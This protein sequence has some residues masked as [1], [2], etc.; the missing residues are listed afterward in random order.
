LQDGN[1]DELGNDEEIEGAQGSDAD[2]GGEDDEVGAGGDADDELPDENG[3]DGI[4]ALPDDENDDGGEEE[5]GKRRRR[6]AKPSKPK[7]KKKAKAVVT[8]KRPRNY[9][10]L[11][12]GHFDPNKV[13]T[14]GCGAPIPYETRNF[15]VQ[16]EFDLMVLDR[17]VVDAS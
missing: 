6:K 8:A 5:S 12:T 13:D 15:C 14:H 16:T 9:P 2:A 7:R 11:L 4:G 10:K 17:M 3:D 1:D